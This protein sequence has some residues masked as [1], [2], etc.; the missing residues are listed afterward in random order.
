MTQTEPLHRFRFLGR[1]ITFDPACVCPDDSLQ[2]NARS[3]PVRSLA[4]DISGNC[5]LQCLYCAESSTLPARQPMG[6]EVLHRSLDL[7][8][9]DS[10]E[11]CAVSVHLGSGEPLLRPSLVR[12]IGEIAREHKAKSSRP[13]DLYLTTN[14]TLLDDPLIAN[15]HEYGWNLK[16]SIDGPAK[17]HDRFR[18]DKTGGPSFDRVCRAIRQV[19]PIMGDT[20]S[21]TSVLCHGT[22]PS[23]VFY[24]LAGLGVRRIELVPVALA[25]NPALRLDESDLLAYRQFMADYV[26]R[27]ALGEDLPTHIRFKKRLQRVMGYFNTSIACDAS[28]TFLAVGPDGTL[29]PCFRFAGLPEYA[30]GHLDTGVDNERRARFTA[31]TGRPYQARTCAGCWVSPI[32]GGPCFAVADLMC[33]GQPDPV[34]CAI[35]RAETEAALY[36]A[37]VLREQSPEILLDLAGIPVVFDEEGSLT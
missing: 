8:F 20:F 6:E 35:A 13:V 29:Y 11:N 28:R 4:L 12:T 22:D 31:G 7:L 14:G 26:R 32:C 5:N 1:E 23:S 25:N 24:F 3:Y 37:E 15:L 18:L 33:G 17:V 36:L 30:L 10:P 2:V 21:T 9:S 16:I 27:L 19:V 34:F